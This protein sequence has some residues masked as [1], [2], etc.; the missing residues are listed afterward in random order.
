MVVKCNLTANKARKWVLEI[1]RKTYSSVNQLAE[2]N[3]KWRGD[4]AIGRNGAESVKS[5]QN[6]PNRLST[7]FEVELSSGNLLG[8]HVIDL[9]RTTRSTSLYVHAFG[10]CEIINKN[11]GRKKG[12]I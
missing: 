8:G 5:L 6:S 4:S 12:R 3:L 7:L 11:A 10:T 2:S 9:L 1:L